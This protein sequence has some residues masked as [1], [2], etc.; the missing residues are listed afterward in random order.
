MISWAAVATACKPEE[1]KRLIVAPGTEAGSPARIRA[2][3]ATFIPCGPRGSPQPRITSAISAGSNPGAWSST[4]RRQWAAWSS[5]RVRFSDPR[6]DLASGVRAVATTTASLMA[7]GL[8]SAGAG[9]GGPSGRPTFYPRLA[10]G[11]TGPPPTAGAGHR[12]G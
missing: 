3:R 1:Q 11:A 10:V 5:G 12:D 8:L 9:R 7:R 6:N 4:A 2:T